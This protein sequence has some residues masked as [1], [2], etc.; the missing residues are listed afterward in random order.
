MMEPTVKRETQTYFIEPGKLLT[1]SGESPGAS[2]LKYN[3]DT[4]G[5]IEHL[6]KTAGELKLD[7]KIHEALPFADLSAEDICDL[8]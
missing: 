7:A 4:G 8:F 6:N 3:D 2:D 5:L 1:P